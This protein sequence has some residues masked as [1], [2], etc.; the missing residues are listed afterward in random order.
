M[1]AVLSSVLKPLARYFDDPAVIE[2]RMSEPRQVII[3]RRGKG[4]EYIAD[5]SLTLSCI[6]YICRTLAN[7]HGFVFNLSSQ[8]KISC[9][10][11]VCQ[12][13][14]E[15]LLGASVQSGLSL[16]IR[17]KHPFVPTW[18]DLGVDAVL[19][20][21]LYDAMAASKNMIISGAT[22]TGKT[23]LLNMLLEMVPTSRRIIGVE[24]T[25]EINL[26]RFEQGVGLIADR[27]ANSGSSRVDWKQLNDHTNRITPDHVI[28][29]EISTENAWPAL[30]S[31]NSGITGFLCTIHAESPAQVLKRKFDQN[32]AW[33]GNPMPNVNEY[34]CDLI[35]VIIQ[36]KRSNDGLRR[37]TEVF[38]PR[39]NKHILLAENVA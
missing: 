7:K 9:I 22:N 6:E 1:D 29:G 23:T 2:L 30:A 36:L 5:D 15:C 37:I 12:H 39:N 19:Q 20:S 38:E 18:H 35:D 25:P 13:R 14:F 8:P 34:L 31:L 4:L 24:D 32:I 3:D 11:P 33:S 10:I 21:Y 27:E 16:A 28:F 17:C 26:N